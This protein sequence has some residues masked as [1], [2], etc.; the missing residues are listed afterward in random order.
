MITLLKYIGLFFYEQLKNAFLEIVR[1]KE[2]AVVSDTVTEEDIEHML[3]VANVHGVF[4]ILSTIITT[5]VVVYLFI[6]GFY[7][8]IVVEI[9][10]EEKILR[11]F[12]KTAIILI[13]ASLIVDIMSKV[14]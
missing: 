5:A 2:M 9:D 14:F 3:T 8:E 12:R 11:N 10:G 13:V 4:V 6:Y 7:D 1:I